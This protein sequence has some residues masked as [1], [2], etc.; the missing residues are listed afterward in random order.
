VWKKYYYPTTNDNINIRHT[1][2]VIIV[3][4][5]TSITQLPIKLL[6]VLN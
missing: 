1:N 5:V 3:S 2:S 4:K 6:V